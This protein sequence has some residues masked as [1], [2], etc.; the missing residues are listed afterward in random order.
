MKK[1]KDKSG[2]PADLLD[3][4]DNDQ[5]AKMDIYI[6]RWDYAQH[7]DFFIPA[8]ARAAYTVSLGDAKSTTNIKSKLVKHK[9]YAEYDDT[10]AQDAY[11]LDIMN[12]PS[13]V[14]CFIFVN[15]NR[16][17]IKYKYTRY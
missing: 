8:C 10:A 14:S 13:P 12:S 11:D 15:I 1:I 5:P 9:S 6:D 4:Y 2:A 17:L 7:M 3:F 16:L